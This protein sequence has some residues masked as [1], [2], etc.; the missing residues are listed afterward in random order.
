MAGT[1]EG[2]YEQFL[3]ACYTWM[4]G[5]HLVQVENNRK[6]LI[7]FGLG[8]HRGG[9]ALDLGCGSGYQSLALAGLGF[10]V[11]S[12]D[13]SQALL[14]ELS[15]MAADHPIAAIRGDMLRS[16][17]YESHGPFDA[18]VC[19]GDSLTHAPS[20]RQVKQLLQD[21]YAQTRPGGQL[22][23]SF[24][25]LST[26]LKGIDRAIPVRLDEHGLM[27]TFLEYME[28]HVNVHDI[29]FTQKDGRWQMTK[30]DY[31]KLRLS[32]DEAVSMLAGTGFRN[33]RKTLD[34]GFTIIAA[35]K[36]AD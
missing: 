33:I 9:K 1:V 24:R 32:G 17:T 5:G 6:T 18:V 23:L 28:S 36:S 13:T 20:L 16:E 27:S 2:H 26:E 7:K 34:Q 4:S 3:A 35:E 31:Q 15:S 8:A 30:S 29:L 25:D 10:S 12:V 14:D 11:I 22:L 19:M 21:V